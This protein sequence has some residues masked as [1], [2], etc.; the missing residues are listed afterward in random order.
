MADVRLPAIMVGGRSRV[1]VATMATPGTDVPAA[2]EW[3]NCLGGL[4][5]LLWRI[6][7]HK[8]RID[9]L[10]SRA[11][12]HLSVD[13]VQ[14]M[15]NPS[16]RR[17]YVHEDDIGQLDNVMRALQRGEGDETVFRLPTRN[18]NTAWLK[19]SGYADPAHPGYVWGNIADI[20]DIVGAIGAK[21]G[22]GTA[23]PRRTTRPAGIG[24]SFD[25][26]IAEDGRI[27]T[28]LELL[29]RNQVGPTFDGI[30][31]SDIIQRKNEVV[32]YS[33]GQPFDTMEPAQVYSYE[34]TI[35][36][37]VIAFGLDHL[38]VDDTFD[39]IKAIDWALFIPSGIRSYFAKPFFQGKGLHS[40]LILCS[41]SPRQF[42]ESRIG[43]FEPLYAPFTESVRRWRK[44]KKKR[45]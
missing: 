22:R 27:E 31:F 4:C 39:S 45:K 14:L 34:G 44:A 1:R 25:P 16:F 3:E 21:A 37:T 15:K 26:A 32:V 24:A 7:V 13:V 6:E 29:Y 33:Y 38:I 20:T 11:C 43:E 35:A 5:V 18:G 41:T 12:G 36:E 42:P 28:V 10:S 8:S 17:Q 30:L 9:V 40:V 23:V 2:G 19:L